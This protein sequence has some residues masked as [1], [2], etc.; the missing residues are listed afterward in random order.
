MGRIS[1]CSVD[2][3]FIKN[4]ARTIEDNTLVLVGGAS[5]LATLAIL[6]AKRT[7]A[8]DMTWISGNTGAVNSIPPFLPLTTH[9]WIMI[10]DSSIV[11]TL[12]SMFDI[13]SRGELDRMFL[14]GAQIDKYGN[15]NVTLIGSEHNIKTKLPGGAGGCNL[16]GDA[17]NFTIWTTRHRARK[18]R[19]KS[20]Y[21]LVEN[22][23]FITD[24]GHITPQG[25]RQ[26]LDLI[27]DGPDWV[28]TNL[29]IF[30]FEKEKKIMRLRCLF[31]D[32]TVEDILENTEF[33][34][35]VADN[36]AKVDLP[37]PE[38]VAII[39]RF[40]PLEVRKREF[41]PEELTRTF[42]L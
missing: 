3:V 39:R 4:L 17:K 2:E 42:R 28:V 12:D 9:D 15:L 1:E 22:T 40:D 5:P 25:T 10:K 36:V 38:E 21:T 18:I 8:P 41:P 11:M 29:G 19:G 6:L 33:R 14:G 31:P 35:L 7:H 32:M 37:S 16:S 20:V 26:A 13:C 27:G 34:P 30:D 24:V 23:H